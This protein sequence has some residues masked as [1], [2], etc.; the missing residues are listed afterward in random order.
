MPTPKSQGLALRF[1]AAVIAASLM[2]VSLSAQTTQAAMQQDPACQSLTPV[3]AGGPAPKSADTVVVRWLS[4][5]N[6]ELAY[7][8]NVFLLD[9]YY[10]QAPRKPSIGVAVGDLNKVNAIF[11]SH[12]HFDHV[13]D[14][15]SIAKQTGATIV[16]AAVGNDA[17]LKRS[18]VPAKQFKAVKNAD[19]LHYPGV[20]VEAVSGLH[21]SRQALGIPADYV[22]K[23]QAAIQA[24]ALQ[25]PFTEAEQKR[26]ADVRSRGDDDPRIAAEG[27]IN[28]LFTFGNDFKVMFVGSHGGITD[29]QRQLAQRVPSVDVALLPYLFFDAGI[30]ALVD[31]VKLLRPSTVFLGNQDGIGTMGWASNYPPAL[32]IRD[33]SPKTRTMD[34]IYR[35]PVC[36]NTQSKE[37]VIG[38]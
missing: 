23:Q 21:N 8:G 24:A 12:A 19:V 20:V 2:T 3:S 32:A 25:Q 38:W 30:P 6:Y 28:Y 10:D 16:G 26:D 33:V 35:T 34:V 22:E 36:F 11:V 27:V 1:C 18:A 13:S 15:P 7:R 9:A 29:A 5:M 4:H 31:L 14:A 17:Y 37:M